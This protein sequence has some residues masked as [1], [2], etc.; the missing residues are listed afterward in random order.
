[1][2][3]NRFRVSATFATPPGGVPTGTAQVVQYGTGDS[4]LFT[5]FSAQNIELLVKVLN[6]CAFSENAWRVFAAGTTTAGVV[7][8]VSDQVRG[9]SVTITNPL[10]QAFAN[11]VVPI[12]GSCP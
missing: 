12:P 2:S 3:N 4:A 11:V 10:N 6:F 8:T 7:V 5:F 1:M 9:G